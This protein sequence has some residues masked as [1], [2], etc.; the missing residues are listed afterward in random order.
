MSTYAVFR[1]CGH[2]LILHLNSI[3]KLGR[4]IHY[5]SYSRRRGKPSSFTAHTLGSYLCKYQASQQRKSLLLYEPPRPVTELL[6]RSICY[7]T[8]LSYTESVS[9]LLCMYVQQ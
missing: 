8:V 4:P 3:S 9:V 7:L 1:P 6:A 2:I 5:I